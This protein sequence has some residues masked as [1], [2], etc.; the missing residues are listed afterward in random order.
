MQ[1]QFQRG[2]LP[3]IRRHLSTFPIL[4]KSSSQN[5]LS[6]HIPATLENEDSNPPFASI[7]S[8]FIRPLFTD[9]CFICSARVFPREMVIPIY[10]LLILF[11][12]IRS[13]PL[14]PFF[15]FLLLSFLP[16]NISN[17]AIHFQKCMGERKKLKHTTTRNMEYLIF[18]LLISPS[19]YACLIFSRYIHGSF[20]F[21]FFFFVFPYVLSAIYVRNSFLVD[22]SF[23]QLFAPRFPCLH[24]S[25]QQFFVRQRADAL[26]S[27]RLVV[28]Q[29]ERS[30]P[31]S[32]FV[33]FSNF[34]SLRLSSIPF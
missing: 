28:S 25:W 21:V 24:L 20:F 14:P 18:G 29:T 10:I 9:G 2:Q 7:P 16:F 34:I 8:P 11:C 19:I 5:P 1:L 3:V 15:P 13:L 32:S 23:F 26:S 31:S 30:S 17:V 27:F 4:R 22:F 33:I 12:F 6:L